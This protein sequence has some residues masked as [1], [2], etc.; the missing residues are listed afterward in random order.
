M[1]G[2]CSAHSCCVSRES[3]FFLPF[4]RVQAVE[5]GQNLTADFGPFFR[6]NWPFRFYD[7]RL[8]LIKDRSSCPFRVPDRTGKS[9]DSPEK[10]FL[11]CNLLDVI[12]KSM[13]TISLR[14]CRVCP[15]KKSAFWQKSALSDPVEQFEYSW[16][17][18]KD[19]TR[20]ASS[21]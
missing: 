21:W 4:Q 13:L 18:V 12:F 5:S 20:N 17:C 10:Q 3:N 6:W 8:L 1:P 7:G 14:L 15:R 11:R 16:W 2:I 9:G 19:A